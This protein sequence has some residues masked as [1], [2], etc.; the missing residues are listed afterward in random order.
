M[1]LSQEDRQKLEQIINAKPRTI[2]RNE[3]QKTTLRLIGETFGLKP[4]NIV[5]T[6]TIRNE[7][8]SPDGWDVVCWIHWANATDSK[9]WTVDISS[10]HIETCKRVTANHD[11][12]NYIVSDSIQYL[13]D[14]TEK[15]DVLYLDS[16]DFDE[17]VECYNHQLGEIK[18]ALDKLSPNAIVISDDNYKADWSHGKGNYSI[19]WMLDNSFELIALEDSQAILQ[20]VG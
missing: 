15:I 11:K 10:E 9:V 5:A 16:Y 4:I 20:K 3:S 8:E 17:T 12:V 1:E 7:R 18:A 19:P 2:G 6:G 13:K 14:F